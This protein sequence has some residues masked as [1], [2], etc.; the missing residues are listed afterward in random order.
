MHKDGVRAGCTDCHGGDAGRIARAIDRAQARRSSTRSARGRTSSR[1]RHLEDV[2][3]SR[4]TRGIARSRS[5][6]S[7]S[8]SSIP[9]TCASPNKPA[10]RATPRKSATCRRADA[11][12]RHAVGRRALQQRLVSR[13]K[14]RSSA[15]STPPT[16]SRRLSTRCRRR[17]RCMT[18]RQ[19]ILPFLQPLFPFQV[20]QPGNVLRV[21]ERGGRRPLEVG[22]PDPEEEPG[23]PKNRLSNRGLGTLEPHRSGLH[24][25][26]E[27]AAARPDAE[28]HRLER[29]RRRLSLERLHGLPRG[30]RQR[31]IAGALGLVC[32][33]RPSR[34]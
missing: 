14:T 3:Q 27:D 21:F 22:N 1:A 20:T 8:G 30:L 34:A 33:G 32:E 6:P 25:A 28:L 10:G 9:A 5:G 29:R 26:A 7:S 23:R 24:R 11:A 31:S 2:G 4:S 17:R 13:S 15:R 19:G 12:R 18:E 16:A